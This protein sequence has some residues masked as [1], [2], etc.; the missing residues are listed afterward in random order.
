MTT[1]PSRAKHESSPQHRIATAAR[2]TGARHRSRRT[3]LWFRVDRSRQ[4]LR[5]DHTNRTQRPIVLTAPPSVLSSLSGVRAMIAILEGVNAHLAYLRSGD[6]PAYVVG[7]RITAANLAH[8]GITYDVTLRRS[9]ECD[10]TTSSSRSSALVAFDLEGHPITEILSHFEVGELLA[11]R[12]MDA[13]SAPDTTHLADLEQRLLFGLA[14][15]VV[16]Q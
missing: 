1:L 14:T 15:E 8:R 5:L 11:L 2:V 16:D 10:L 3:G 9:A 6:T 13:L 12:L 4:I 7:L